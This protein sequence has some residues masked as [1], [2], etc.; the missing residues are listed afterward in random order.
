[1]VGQIGVEPTVFLMSR[2][3]RPLQSPAMRTDPYGG[4]GW[5]R[6][7]DT[8]GFN[9]VLYQLSYSSIWR[10]A[11]NSN[12]TPCGAIRLA[13][14]PRAFRVHSPNMAGVAG[15][16]PTN[17]GVRDRCLDH[18]ATPQYIVMPYHC[19]FLNPRLKNVMC[20]SEFLVLFQLFSNFFDGY[21]Q[22]PPI[23]RTKNHYAKILIFPLASRSYPRLPLPEGRS[24][25]D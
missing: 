6:T 1:M 4:T 17:A 10:R 3:Y 21:F 24:R 25:P 8:L 9:Q 23:G 16:E 15:L 12:L 18:L 14:G 20:K 2:F 22:K 19:R 13:G 5:N 7:N 11:Q